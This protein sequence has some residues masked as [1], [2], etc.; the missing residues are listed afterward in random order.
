MTIED[1]F[2]KGEISVLIRNICMANEIK[3]LSQI[4]EIEALSAE[5]A[6]DITRK[7]YRNKEIVLGGYD[8]V[9]IKIIDLENR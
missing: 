9:D 5:E 6:V 7:M 8:C 1:I 2:I 3:T 4:I